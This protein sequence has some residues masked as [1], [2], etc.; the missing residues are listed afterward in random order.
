MIFKV[1]FELLIWGSIPSLIDSSL[2][3]SIQSMFRL[4]LVQ[5]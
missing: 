1:L 3:K 5:H 4:Y 2:R